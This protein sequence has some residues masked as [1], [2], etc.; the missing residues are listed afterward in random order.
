MS[1]RVRGNV[2]LIAAGAW[3]QGRSHAGRLAAEGADAIVADDCWQLRGVPYARSGDLRYKIRG[4]AVHGHYEL[5]GHVPP[6]LEP[7]LRLT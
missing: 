7:E 6:A 2:A 5:P 1:E 3:D 4:P